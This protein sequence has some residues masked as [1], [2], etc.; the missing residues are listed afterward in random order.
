MPEHTPEPDKVI[1]PNCCH[2]F[3]AIPE[4]VQPYY[5]ALKKRGV[6]DPEGFKKSLMA[7]LRVL[8]MYFLGE[9]GSCPDCGSSW[10]PHEIEYMA[11][12]GRGECMCRGWKYDLAAILPDL[13]PKEPDDA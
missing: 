12:R 2:Q 10:S 7:H 5:H 1:C 8:Q 3:R 4:E 11:R 6:A 13:F 9:G